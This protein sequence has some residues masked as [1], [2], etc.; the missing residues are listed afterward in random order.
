MK[1]SSDNPVDALAGILY[2]NILF[3]SYTAQSVVHFVNLRTC[4]LFNNFI[5][6]DT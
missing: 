6:F 2:I 1:T 4:T 3:S 5:V